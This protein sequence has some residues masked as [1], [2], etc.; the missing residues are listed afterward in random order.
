MKAI[1]SQ[2]FRIRVNLLFS[3]IIVLIWIRRLSDRWLRLCTG[4]DLSR[5]LGFQLRTETA[6]QASE[7]DSSDV[8]SGLL[9]NA[10]LRLID[11]QESV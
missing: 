2:R 8:N 6:V 11:I 7:F 4:S 3:V 10:E 5:W 9:V 1:F